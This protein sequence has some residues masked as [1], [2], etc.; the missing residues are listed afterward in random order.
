L[1][2]RLRLHLVEMSLAS[3]QHNRP[4]S[5]KLPIEPA[6]AVLR[7]LKLSRATID[8][9]IAAARTSRA[10]VYRVLADL[11]KFGVQ[12]NYDGRG[13]YHVIDWGL[14]NPDKL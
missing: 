4:G 10:T 12:V 14:I 5:H 3:R 6:L 11:Q 2:N 8:D 9:L 7:R 13:S 1:R